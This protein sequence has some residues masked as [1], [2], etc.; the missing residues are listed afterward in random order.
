MKSQMLFA[1]VILKIVRDRF[2]QERGGEVGRA[3]PF[4]E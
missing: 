4:V 2:L 3:A 1:L